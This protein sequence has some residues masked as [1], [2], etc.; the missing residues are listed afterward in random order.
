MHWNRL[1][2]LTGVIIGIIGLSMEG[3][4]TEGES[5]LPALNEAGTGL[6]DGIPTIWG[7]LATWAQPVLVILIL[8]VVVIA[9][10]GDRAKAMDRTSS[11]IVSVIGVA[12]LAYAVYKMIDTGDSADAL[13]AGFAQV[14][15]AGGLPAAFTVAT[16]FGFL[17]LIVGTVLVIFGGAM[18]F[19]GSDDE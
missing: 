18:G 9:V 3:L 13:Q 4:T 16:G 12:L 1:I 6:P 8:A 19:V 10:R 5:F 2:A 7:G 14:E 17:I 15:A 11:M